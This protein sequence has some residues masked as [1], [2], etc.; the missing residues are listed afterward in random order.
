MEL[1]IKEALSEINR[2]TAEIIDQVRL[3]KT[4]KTLL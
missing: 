4:F 2:G 1:K 3:E